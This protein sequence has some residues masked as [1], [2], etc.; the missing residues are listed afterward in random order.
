LVLELWGLGDVLLTLP[1]LRAAAQV[2]AVT[3]LAK[4]AFAPILERFAEE[5]DVLPFVAPWTA[6]SGKYR[7]HE[8]PWRSI[9]R[10][11][12]SL[13]RKEFSIVVS[14]R[15]DPRDHLLMWL[16]GA[17]RR[18]GFG[19][20]GSETLL[21]DSLARPPGG[22]RYLLWQ[23]AARALG[24]KL[25]PREELELPE[26]ACD[27]PIV[28]HT[29]AA[30]PIRVWP[31]NRYLKLAERLRE[32]R[33]DVRVICD[34]EQRAFFEQ[35][36]E[37]TSTPDSLD[38]LVD[39]ISGTR[40]FIGNDSGPGHLAAS[41]GVPTFTIFGPQLPELFTPLHPRAAW[42]EGKPCSHKPCSDSCC[43]PRAH[44]MLELSEDEVVSGVEL[45]LSQ[46]ERVSSPGL[47]HV[48]EGVVEV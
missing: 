5:V 46:L 19:R 35:Q 6:F 32:E 22:H 39:Q 11:V 33:H 1:F 40:A 27:G 43:H 14:A 13:R 20:L 18:V 15:H 26:P 28:I 45:F 36:G 25:C 44:C 24:L 9:T 7:L 2:H 37:E 17:P 47:G 23:A 34:S 8:W 21:T 38:A 30:Q 10:C 16:S 42:I 12:A 3:V 29:G 48:Q 31:L 41:L 4:P